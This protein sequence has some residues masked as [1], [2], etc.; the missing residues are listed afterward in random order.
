MLKGVDAELKVVGKNHYDNNKND[1]YNAT[2]SV[3]V[4]SNNAKSLNRY[5]FC[6]K[7][8]RIT[9]AFRN[10]LLK[11]FDLAG[12][13]AKIGTEDIKVLSKKEGV[14]VYVYEQSN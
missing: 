6:G 8:I 9:T 12:A 10:K 13:E 7:A 5:L 11:Q 2:C 4:F 3:V 1:K 14:D